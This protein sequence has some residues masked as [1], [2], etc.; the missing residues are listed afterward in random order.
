MAQSGGNQGSKI[1]GRGC[2]VSVI[3]LALT[4]GSY[5]I[6][7]DGGTYYVFGGLIAW[8]VIMMIW[9]AIKAVTG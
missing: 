5:L 1:M 2:L 4:F 3:G 7:P 8:G 6:A 9:G